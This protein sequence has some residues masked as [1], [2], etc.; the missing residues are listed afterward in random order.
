M[1]GRIAVRDLFQS[2]RRNEIVIAG[3]DERKAR[4]AAAGYHSSRVSHRR[5]DAREP[6]SLSFLRDC[7]VLVNCAQYQHNL[8]A[9]GGALR[10]GTGYVDLGGLYH[11]TLRQLRL[12]PRF[13]KERLTAILG[14]GSTPGI[15]NV[16]AAAASGR[17]DRVQEIDIRFGAADFSVFEGG[18]FPVP[19]S[20]ST[21]I[22]EFTL[23]PKVFR[24]GRMTEEKPLGGL[25]ETEFPRPIGRK[26]SF[27]TLHSELATFPSSFRRLGVRDVSFR[28]SFDRSFVDSI[29]F[30]ARAGMSSDRPV[31]FNGAKIAPREFLAKV[32]SMRPRPKVRKLD[33]YECLLVELSGSRRGKRK[34]VRAA[35]MARPIPG[36]GAAAGDVDTGTPPSIVA[37][38]M[39]RGAV[40]EPGVFPPEFHV[41]AGPFFAELE[42][43]GMRIGM[44]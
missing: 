6:E 40:D 20:I 18:P 24:G 33:D 34:K 43:R 5:A 2:E 42:K 28:V 39:A 37:Q 29:L 31:E 23:P 41:P 15:T 38:M 25:I 21:L 36:W 12:R 7:D 26:S 30:L 19:Y 32:L 9:M 44:R 4:K 1:M 16:L 22:D 8:E 10:A 3:P 17:L 13:R 14:M 35:C 27:Y 11:M